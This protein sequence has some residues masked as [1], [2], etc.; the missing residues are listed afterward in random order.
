MKRLILYIFISA[1]FVVSAALIT[2]TSFPKNSGRVFLF[3]LLVLIDIYLWRSIRKDILKNGGW[4]KW[5]FGGIY[6][7]PYV[8]FVT[9]ALYSL[10]HPVNDWGTAS[11]VYL[12]GILF[13]FYASK[14]LAVIFFLLADL[15]SIL[16]FTWKFTTAK[17]QR[18]PFR[19][20]VTQMSRGRFLRTVGLAGGG[21]LF[22]GML[23]GVLKWA[24]DFRVRRHSIQIP[25]LPKSFS[26]LKIVQIS[27]LH[28]GSWISSEP[29][30]EAV[31]MINDL[32]PDIILFT[33]DL[34]NS[35]TNEAIRFRDQL[36]RLKAPDG[37][38]A[39]LGNHDYGDYVDWPSEKAKQQN[40][41]M[42]YDFYS[43][44][45]WK[46][47]NNSHEIITKGDDKMAIVGVENW[48]AI[49]RF[50]R[51][52]DLSKALMGT[53]GIPSKVLLSHDPSHWEKIVSQV[54]PDI[55]VTFSGHTHG[56]Q[57]GVELKG[58]RWSLA[59]YM[60]KYWAGL[61]EVRKPGKS[62]YLY[63]NR[64]LGMVGYPGRVGILPEITEVTLYA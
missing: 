32:D 21:L 51:Y 6:W 23:I 15:Y 60:Y 54:Y 2:E 26:G 53:E 16:K 50:P 38:F 44:I 41:Q 7:L 25:G 3:F 36:N 24:Y 5:I 13:I 31:D 34:V 22:S 56:F 14:L 33:G 30:D 10:Y 40:M 17:K 29:L 37:I 63:V 58:F 18:K 1:L 19:Q 59:Q 61:Y 45:G 9:A 8:T 64:G 20:E 27:D 42:L 12:F 47:L 28:L 4:W 57:F 46:L 35:T 49:S 43:G 11:S 55:D 52:G 48:S 39:C 62:Q